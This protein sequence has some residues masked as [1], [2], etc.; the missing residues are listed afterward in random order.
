MKPT[1]MEFWKMASLLLT[2]FFVVFSPSAAA[3]K[4]EK[5][6][7]SPRIVEPVKSD[8][9][10]WVDRQV[11]KGE[12]VYLSGNYLFQV[13]KLRSQKV[14]MDFEAQTLYPTVTE[15]LNR[16]KPLAGGG[17]ALVFTEMARRLLDP[18]ADVDPRVK[19]AVSERVEAF[20]RDPQNQPRGHYLA[21]EQ[22]KRY[23]LGL[24]FLFKATFDVKVDKQWFEQRKYML[25]PFESAV[26]MLEILSSP[27]N[28]SVLDLF[29]QVH[30]FYSSLLGPED[31][32]TFH[33]LLSD[34]P[35]LTREGVY[36]YALKKNLPKINKEMGIGI[37]F[38][39]ERFALHQYVIEKLSD[40]LLS[41]DV[42]V[43]RKKILEALDFGNIFNGASVKKSN[44]PDGKIE[45]LMDF[46]EE[47]TDGLA[48]FYNFS[49]AAVLNLPHNKDVTLGLNDPAACV[50]ALSEQTILATKQKTLVA[51]SMLPSEEPIKKNA[52]LHV[53]PGIDGFLEL[54]SR[55]EAVLYE[56]CRVETTLDW[57]STLISASKSGMPI[58]S[59][60]SQGQDVLDKVS[61][62]P[63]DPTVTVD[64][65]YYSGRTDKAFLQWAVAPFVV[66]FTLST[67]KKVKGMSMVFFYGWH[68]TAAKGG[69]TPL[70][71]QT[72]RQYFLAGKYNKFGSLIKL[73]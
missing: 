41:K 70:T 33:D 18:S 25:F 28:Q 72:W 50:T 29:N 37:Q 31:L 27:D 10:N 62:L 4:L 14:L 51:K 60:T 9:Q 45:G 48:S 57:Y 39:G 67:G 47:L 54:L 7:P 55:G 5:V 15:A 32:P 8:A 17:Q 3:P 19:D 63:L 21:S 16:L 65:F 46:K 64:V 43:N 35:D 66:E 58:D 11:E 49:M 12:D 26:E 38:L 42:I 53:Q 2:L 69:K 22:L 6:L 23:F 73:P 36:Q 34:K 61:N 44:G 40:A 30:L 56:L 52:Y 71:N 1:L 68:D 24:S 13:M 20:L 59:K